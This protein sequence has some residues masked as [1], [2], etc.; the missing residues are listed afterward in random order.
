MGVLSI[1]LNSD[2]S[3]LRDARWTSL[4]LFFAPARSHA[5]YLYYIRRT[6]STSRVTRYIILYYIYI[7]LY[8]I[9]TPLVE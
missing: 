4:F 7:I 1:F 6:R 8:Y 5:L 9:L 2:L 3:V